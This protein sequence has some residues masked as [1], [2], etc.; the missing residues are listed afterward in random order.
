MGVALSGLSRY[1]KGS[2]QLAVMHL[3]DAF[4][5]CVKLQ[6]ILSSDEGGK[7]VKKESYMLDFLEA[8]WIIEEK[9]FIVSVLAIQI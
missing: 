7:K 8:V 6:N 4:D 9:I 5:G 2:K 1:P 3:A